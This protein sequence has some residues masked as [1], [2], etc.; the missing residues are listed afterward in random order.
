MSLEIPENIWEI[1]RVKENWSEFSEDEPICAKCGERIINDVPLR[2]WK[3]E[4]LGISFH[5][6]CVFKDVFY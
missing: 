4:N 2:L 1:L 6:K 5:L 3:D